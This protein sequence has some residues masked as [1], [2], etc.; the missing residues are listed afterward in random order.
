MSRENN[1]YE[2]IEEEI[3]LRDILKTLSKWKYTIVS[4]TMVAMLLSGIIS[5]YFLDPVYEAST[6]VAVA[7]TENS[8]NAESSN[9]EDIVDELGELPYMSV[10]SCVQ[11]LKTA[12]VLQTVIDKMKLPYSRRQLGAMITAEQ[13]EDTNLMKITISNSD[14]K[15]AAQISNTLREE[16]V[17]YITQINNQKLKN[18]VETMENKLLQGEEDE[19]EAAN[20]KLKEY[21]LSSRSIEF[22]ST[23]LA[24]KNSDLGTFQ[25]S[26]ALLEIQYAGL[27]KGV[28][29][30]QKSLAE[31]PV[32]LLTN[33]TADGVLPV[34]MDGIDIKDG[35]VVR[36]NINEAYIN[37]YNLLNDKSSQLAET[38]AGIKT[39]KTNIA[40]LEQEIPD[41]EAQLTENQIEET[42]LQNEVTR[43]ETN[44]D[45]LTAKIAELKISGNINLAENSI[46]T[47]SA[48]LVPE[49]P[50]KPNKMLNVA[51]AG[52]LGLMMSTLA[53]FFIEYMREG[54][55]SEETGVRGKE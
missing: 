8:K 44:V 16:F 36:E 27:E 10:E 23:Q 25:S 47:T 19:L 9:M 39:T 14:P 24:Q 32:T 40:R 51:I 41:L 3:D 18:S 6:I 5:I 11:Q 50:V 48:A 20:D 49:K 26:L 21:K 29:Q 12:S 34:D 52:I 38:E 28:E 45:L 15:L 2:Y 7:Q 54:D 13:L 33:E 4:V 55:E 17:L 1:G 53:V 35:K 37:L 43:R 31:T 22:L 42:K 46:T 30:L